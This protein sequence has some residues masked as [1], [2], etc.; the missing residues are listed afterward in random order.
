[1]PSHGP[2]QPWESGGRDDGCYSVD[3]LGAV[4]VPWLGLA[5]DACSPKPSSWLSTMRGVCTRSL[6][7]AVEAMRNACAQFSK[8]LKEI[9]YAVNRSVWPELE[10]EVDG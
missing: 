4:P 9:D 3:W 6:T 1:M 8:P 7:S 10:A 2:V 5:M